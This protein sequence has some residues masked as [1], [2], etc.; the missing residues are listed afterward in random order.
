MA[1][2]QAGPRGGFLVNLAVRRALSRHTRRRSPMSYESTRDTARTGANEFSR[3]VA[4]AGDAVRRHAPTAVRDL[5]E[6][7]PSSTAVTAAFGAGLAW[8]GLRSGGL[9]GTAALLLGAWAVARAW[10][11]LTGEG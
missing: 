11:D 10:P 5:A 7:A 6:H 9:L 4:A 8:W 2:V 3:H 1:A